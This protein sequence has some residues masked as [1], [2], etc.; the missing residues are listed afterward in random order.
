MKKTIKHISFLVVLLLPFAA[1]AQAPDGMYACTTDE[2]CIVVKDFCLNN[3]RA[4]NRGQTAAF[5]EWAKEMKPYVECM[6]LKPSPKPDA[7]CENR[8]RCIIYSPVPEKK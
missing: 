1:A 5:E 2:D 6:P 8:N 7:V 3:W 4:I